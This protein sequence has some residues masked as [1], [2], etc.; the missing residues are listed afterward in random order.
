[1]PPCTGEDIQGDLHRGWALGGKG[2]EVLQHRRTDICAQQHRAEGDDCGFGILG[3][4]GGVCRCRARV[5]EGRAETGGGGI[6]QGTIRGRRIRGRR[7]KRRQIV[8]LGVLGDER[9]SQRV[10]IHGG[11]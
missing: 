4:G 1:V 8:E 11:S 6:R 10:R 9:G 3:V 7:E 5:E 2:R